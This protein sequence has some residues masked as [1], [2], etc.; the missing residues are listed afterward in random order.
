MRDVFQKEGKDS[1]Q[2]MTEV[3]LSDL[4]IKSTVTWGFDGMGQ[5]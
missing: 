1:K 5:F 2:V 4:E 3:R